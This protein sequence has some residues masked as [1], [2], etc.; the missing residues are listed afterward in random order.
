MREG[1]LKYALDTSHLG[2]TGGRT[3]MYRIS[4]TCGIGIVGLI[5]LTGVTTGARGQGMGTEGPGAG[6][7]SSAAPKGL[8]RLR[9]TIVCASCSLDEAK[10]AH[11]NLTNL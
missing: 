10:A 11:P 1:G 3:C 9:A 6:G 5:L 7:A 8:I 2:F 4:K